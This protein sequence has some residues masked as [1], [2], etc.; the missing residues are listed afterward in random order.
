MFVVPL[1]KRLADWADCRFLRDL[2]DLKEKLPDLVNHLRETETVEG[3][4]E[5][6]TDRVAPVVHATLVVPEGDVPY[7]VATVPLAPTRTDHRPLI[8]TRAPRNALVQKVWI[9][10]DVL[11]Q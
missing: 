5:A 11:Y 1:R 10:D 3:I 9:E 2:T 8:Q 7:Q 4:A 6:V